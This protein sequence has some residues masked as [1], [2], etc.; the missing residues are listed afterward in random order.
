MEDQIIVSIPEQR[1]AFYKSGQLQRSYPISTS[2]FGLGSEENS[3]KTPLGSFRIKGKIGDGAVH[4]TIFK[5]REPA[6][7]WTKDN[8]AKDPLQKTD[9]ILSRILRLDG[10]DEGNQNTYER[11]IYIHGTNDETQIG[12]AVSHGCVR[13]L[14][15]DIEELFE[16]VSDGLG[17]KICDSPLPVA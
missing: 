12:K 15:H 13:M 7:V 10:C 17:V 11:F 6:G 8:D 16:V 5:G 9:A 1:L 14:S 3:F 2:K 4:K